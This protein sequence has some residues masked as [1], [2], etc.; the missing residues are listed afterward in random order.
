MK[1]PKRNRLSGCLQALLLAAAAGLYGNAGAAPVDGPVPAEAA[2]Q[3]AGRTVAAR[4]AEM[5]EVRYVYPDIGLRYASALRAHAAAGDYDA[6]AGEALAKRLLADL[7]QTHEDAHLNVIP[8]PQPGPGATEGEGGGLDYVK[9]EAPDMETPAWIAPG[10]AFVRYNLFPSGPAEIEAT[11]KFLDQYG[12]AKAIVFDLRA[13]RGGALG[14]I[15]TIVGRLVSE[16]THLL[17]MATR[18]SLVELMGMPPADDPRMR[19]VEGDPE[20]ISLEHWAL[21]EAGKPR[22][23]SRIYLLTSGR[24]ASAAEHFA[25]AMKVA[26]LG[27]LVGEPTLGANHFGGLEQVAEG[28]SA[29]IPVGRTFDPN[30][31]QDWERT[32]V[33]PDIAVPAGDALAVVLEREGVEAARARAIA[34]EHSPPAPAA[35]PAS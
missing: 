1:M 25:L 24:T 11:A 27:I 2:Q 4:L 9:R 7:E 31:G 33:A 14:E 35:K 18:K 21:P 32:G 8:D 28:L 23:R 20:F 30:T 6:L 5:M 22:I 29:F 12:G 17:T 26:G 34:D 13:H 15:D 10:I 3:T 19:L 16:P